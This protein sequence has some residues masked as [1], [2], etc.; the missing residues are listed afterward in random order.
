MFKVAA[1]RMIEWPVLVDI[2]QDGGKVM[3]ASFDGVFEI[4][5][6]EEHDELLREGGDLLERVFKGAKRLKDE[7]DQPLEFSEAV[8]RDLQA[9]S[10]VRVALM[11]AY[12]E[13]FHGRKAERKNA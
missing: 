13:A 9:I 8:K 12:Y 2:P 10:Y 6:Q 5:P 11:R 4:L 7:H 3:K 1:V